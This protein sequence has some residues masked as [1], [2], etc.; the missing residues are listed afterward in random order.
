MS[1]LVCSASVSFLPVPG[2][3]MAWQL[4]CHS[5]SHSPRQN[6]PDLFANRAAVEMVA[7]PRL[8]AL[9]R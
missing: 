9:R 8:P 7:W 1:A 5:S 3:R 6:I 4:A 2:M